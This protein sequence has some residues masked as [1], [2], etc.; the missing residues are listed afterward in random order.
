MI[1]G[2]EALQLPLRPWT[3]HAC[4]Y[5]DRAVLIKGHLLQ[6]K[7]ASVNFGNGIALVTACWRTPPNT[8]DTSEVRVQYSNLPNW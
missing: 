1:A 3:A 6:S 5:V 4:A 8:S 2:P 7:T